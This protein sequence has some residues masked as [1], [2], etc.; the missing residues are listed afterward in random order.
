[1]KISDDSGLKQFQSMIEMKRTIISS[2]R[3]PVTGK[4]GN[5]R[6]AAAAERLGLPLPKAGGYGARVHENRTASQ[7]VRQ[8]RIDNESKLSSIN[9]IRSFENQS[10]DLSSATGIHTISNGGVRPGEEHLGR[11]IDL[12]A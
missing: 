7:L 9:R 6:F 8:Q 1:M 2:S 12:Y 10:T 4:S 11:N 5:P 3:I